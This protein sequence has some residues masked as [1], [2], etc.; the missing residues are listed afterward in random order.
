MSKY[1]LTEQEEELLK[2]AKLNQ[3]KSIEL[4]QEMDLLQSSWGDKNASHEDFLSKI[5]GQLGISRNGQTIGAKEFKRESEH[6]KP[7]EWDELV[8]EAN[9]KYSENI[10]FEDL[11]NQEEFVEAYKRVDKIEAEFKKKTGLTKKDIAFLTIAIGL[12]CVRQYVIDPL[13][14]EKREKSKPNDEKG[15]KKNADPGWYYVK[16]ENILL[17]RVPFDAQNYNHSNDAT[18]KGF[19]KGA[20]DHRYVTLGH[21]PI[22]GW[23]FGTANI[24]TSTITRYDMKSAHVKNDPDTNLNYIHS[25]ADNGKII[26]AIKDRWN[27]GL[28]DGKVAIALAVCREAMH[29]YSDVKTK[30][31]LPIPGIMAISPKMAEKLAKYGI[32]AASV[33]TEVTLASLINWLVAVVHRLCFDETEDE[34][35]FYEVRTRKIILYSNLIASTSNVIACYF[36]GNYQ[37]LDVGG[38]LVTIARLISDVRF[39]CKVKDEFVESKMDEHFNEI[40]EEIEQLYEARF[41]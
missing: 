27:S 1:K 22:L 6:V 41:S 33:G 30:D 14:K 7:L 3:D 13:I 12:Q 28:K 31:S 36:T 17:N 5:E 18:I 8:S 11:L 29:L 10:D 34:E 40:Q 21:D 35:Q 26:E 2:V 37:M 20:M 25:R 24:L 4:K 38:L 16:T 15:E 9:Q 39:I 19:L 32:D 23:I